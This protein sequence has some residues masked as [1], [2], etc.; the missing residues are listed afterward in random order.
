MAA[1]RFPAGRRPARSALARP[2]VRAGT[3]AAGRAGRGH[4]LLQSRTRQ[5]APPGSP[6]CRCL[7]LAALISLHLPAGR[8]QSWPSGW[9]SARGAPR[10]DGAEQYAHGGRGARYRVG[11]RRLVLV[12]RGA[13][14]V[15]GLDHHGGP[16]R[17]RAERSGGERVGGARRHSI[18]RGCVGSTAVGLSACVLRH[19]VLQ[20]P[21]PPHGLDR[22]GRRGR[23]GWP[24]WSASAGVV[25][26]GRVTPSCPHREPLDDPAPPGAPARAPH[27]SSWGA[28]KFAACMPASSQRHGVAGPASCPAMVPLGESVR[29]RWRTTARARPPMVSLRQPCGARPGASSRRWW[30][31]ESDRDT[32]E[33]ENP[34]DTDESQ[35]QRSCPPLPRARQAASEPRRATAATNAG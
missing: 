13:A 16:P 1:A 12:M 26:R 6:R 27:G 35:Q 34:S 14:A 31:P 17:R 20:P 24:G 11:A 25:A 2:C 18:R 9:A 8:W 4:V 23:C 28:D 10:V 22:H 15:L 19:P 7:P 32:N 33:Q 5:R 21:F 29:V 3:C 30:T